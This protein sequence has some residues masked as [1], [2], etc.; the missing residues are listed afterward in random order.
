M[1]CEYRSMLDAAV[2]L[3]NVKAVV[4]GFS[5]SSVNAMQSCQKVLF[6]QLLPCSR[7]HRLMRHG[8]LAQAVDFLCIRIADAADIWTS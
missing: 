6:C 8:F 3:A 4:P 7:M 5:M 2:S 1:T